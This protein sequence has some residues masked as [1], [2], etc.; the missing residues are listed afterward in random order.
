MTSGT[1]AATSH[2]HTHPDKGRVRS[3]SGHLDELRALVHL[4]RPYRARWLLGVT[5]I[6]VAA[7]V[8]L[9]VAWLAKTAID[10]GIQ[11]GNKTL[12][13]QISVAIVVAIFI[14]WGARWLRF[15][16]MYWTADRLAASL[17]GQIFEHIHRLPMSFYEATT[18]GTLLSRLTNDVETVRILFNRGLT[19]MIKSVVILVGGIAL[20]FSLDWKMALLTLSVIPVLGVMTT[21]YRRLVAPRFLHVRDAI[22]GVTSYAQWSLSWMTFIQ[23]YN[24]QARHIEEFSAANDENRA[25]QMSTIRLGS[26]YYPSTQFLSAFAKGLLIIYGGLQVVDGEVSTG[27]MVAF[28]GVLGMFFTPLTSLSQVFQTYEAGIAAIDKIFGVLHEEPRPDSSNETAPPRD[29]RIEVE[30]VDFAHVPDR[31]VFR[32]LNLNIDAG[33]NVALYGTR[34]GG[35]TTLAHLL[36]R[37][38]NVTS[39]RI[40]IGGVDIR[41]IPKAT[42][43][44]HVGYVG[45]RPDLIAGTLRDNVASLDPDV[46]DEKITELIRRLAGEGFLD[47]FP[48]RLDT[49]ITSGG[50]NI[51]DGEVLVIGLVRALMFDP[52]VL[53]IDGATDGLDSLTADQV[54]TALEGIL[55]NQ[56]VI[57]ITERIEVLLVVEEVIVMDEGKVVARGTHADLMASDSTYREMVGA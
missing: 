39:G 9:V 27:A 10:S 45:A 43:R 52:K 55:T 26:I 47:R 40:R 21:V 44:R 35:K 46:S 2:R 42:L 3:A 30:H 4:L 29:G 15:Y 34:G 20:M 50:T 32:D 16:Y 6:T 37:L 48:H 13:A 19:R 31:S 56:T 12:L 7:T 24:Q 36:L 5:G 54:Q 28:F 41:E 51:S 57:V 17:Q 18:V 8:G 53:I 38:H 23:S 14:A 49:R 11:A 25:A 1:E 33:A 22:A